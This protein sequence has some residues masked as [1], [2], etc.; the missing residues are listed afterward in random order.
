MKLPDLDRARC[1]K[2][3]TPAQ[4][5]AAYNEKLPADFPPA[6]APLLKEFKKLHETLFKNSDAWSLDQHR[7]KVMDWLPAH[8]RISGESIVYTQ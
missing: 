5:L 2:P 3:L 7:K 6:T 4:F 8:L 1:E